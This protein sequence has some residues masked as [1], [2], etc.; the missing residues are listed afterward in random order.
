MLRPSPERRLSL[1]RRHWLHQKPMIPCV[2]HDT[3]KSAVLLQTSQSGHY[4]RAGICIFSVCEFNLPT[5][6]RYLSLPSASFSFSLF[7]A[8]PGGLLT[9]ANTTVLRQYLTLTCPCSSDPLGSDEPAVLLKLN[10]LRI[11]VIEIPN[12][13][14][15]CHPFETR[16][17]NRGVTRLVGFSRQRPRKPVFW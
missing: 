9:N 12:E 2:N 11:R 7:R 15:C 6:Y 1:R 16:R 3:A 4:E 17:C 8:L 10:S 13:L 5:N 14:R